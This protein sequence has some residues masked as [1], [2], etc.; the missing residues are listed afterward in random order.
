MNSTAAKL[1]GVS[2][3]YSEK[4]PF[5]KVAVDNVDVTF[6]DGMI[7]GIIGHTGSGKS[8]VA[9][10]INGLFRRRTRYMGK[11]EGDKKRAL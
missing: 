11:P 3:I 9:Q 10:M 8:T 1:C 2:Y 6:E 4:T 7:T 5:M